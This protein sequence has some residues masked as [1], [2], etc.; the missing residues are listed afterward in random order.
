MPAL[1]ERHETFLFVASAGTT[2]ATRVAFAP[3]SNVSSVWERETPVTTTRTETSHLAISSPC[4]ALDAM[5]AVIVALP[6][7]KPLI[8]KEAASTI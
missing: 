4:V 7:F 3:F 2:V 6:N 1:S 8:L 5:R